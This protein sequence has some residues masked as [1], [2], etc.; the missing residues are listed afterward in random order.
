MSII[1]FDLLRNIIREQ[2]VESPG[3]IL[4]KM[5]YGVAETF[6]KN[7]GDQTVKDGMDMALVVYDKLNSVVEYA[8]ALNPLY[9]VRNGR[10]IEVKGNRFSIGSV[11]TD[12]KYDTHIIPVQKND[13]IYIFSDGYADQFGGSLGKKYKFRRF[14]H[15]LITINNM[16]VN[17]QREFLNENIENWMG[18]LEQ[19]DDMLIIG[20]RI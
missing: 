3:E 9:I 14:R 7:I 17:K 5:S 4:N 18:E 2:G 6:S 12:E 13:M 20:F 8:G 15:T 10:I 1:G 16:P 19:V 11:E